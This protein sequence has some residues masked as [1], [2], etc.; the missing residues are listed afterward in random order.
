MLLTEI[1]EELAFAWRIL[2]ELMKGLVVT[3]EL[4]G[5]SLVAGLVLAIPVSMLRTYTRGP[6]NWLATAYVEVFRGTPLLVQ[7]FVV[8]YGLPEMGVVWS[9]FFSAWLALTLNSAAYQSEYIRGA[10]LSVSEGQLL[11]ARSL[12]M[13]PIQA[14]RWVVLPQALRLALPAWSNEV[15][16]MVKY[17][18][19]VYMI[20]VQEL[21]T[22][23]QGIISRTF[24]VWTPLLEVAVVYLAVVYLVT[25]LMDSV[26]RRFRIPGLEGGVERREMV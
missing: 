22:R 24:K 11:A 25:R 10:I 19:V 26:E 3:L 20:A 15:A 12:G 2:P 9:R 21:F 4:T 6:L 23:A 8:Y 13:P 14:F 17:V 18:S 16:Y 7:L 1:A 5:L